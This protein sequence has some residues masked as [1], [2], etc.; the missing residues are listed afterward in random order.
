MKNKRLILVVAI[1]ILI[2]FVSLDSHARTLYWGNSGEDVKRVQQRLIEWGYLRGTADGVFGNATYN[3]VVYFQKKNGLK[4]DGVV[5]TYTL[6]E[7][8]LYN[9]LSR[10]TKTSNKGV[11]T[12]VKRAQEILR[13]KGYYSGNPDGVYGDATYE[14][15]TKFQRD[16]GLVVDG[17]IGPATRKALGMDS[18]AADKNY[19]P[20]N[21]AI[22]NDNDVKLLA[23]VINGE[24]RGE[25]YT[26]KVAVGAVVL[27]RVKNPSFPNS[28]AGV[29]Y[30]PGAFNAVDDGQIYL[31]PQNDTYKAAKDA[32]NGWD[33]T[34]GCIYYWNPK[35]AKNK[36]ML[37][38]TPI[39]TI[40]NHAFAK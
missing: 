9:E 6:K 34:G 2:S 23:M 15:V 17:Y 28:I 4:A 26:G 11:N 33:P 30:E 38:K 12:I 31:D 19:K 22:T 18:V 21:G 5:G 39:I 32:L 8:G 25:I 37:S 7:L 13:T 35:T 29:V 14:A 16:N 1:L 3:A 20:S 36:W 24:A 40:G 10:D 27:N